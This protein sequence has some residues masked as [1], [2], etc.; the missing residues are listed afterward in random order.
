[1][2][3]KSVLQTRGVICIEG[4]D[5]Y[6]F[7][8]TLITNDVFLLETT[9]AI[10]TALLNHH[11]KYLF[12]VFIVQ[13]YQK[14]TDKLFLDVEKA[15]IPAVLKHL[16]L[17]KLRANVTITDRSD[18][19]RVASFLSNDYDSTLDSK[20]TVSNSFFYK[21][22]R[23]PVMGWRF[24]IAAQDQ[25][26]LQGCADEQTYQRHRLQQGIAESA[27]DLVCEKSIILEYGFD[28]LGAIAWNK[29]CYLG[30]ELMA[31][32]KHR[33]E[34]HKRLFK[35]KSQELPPKGTILTQNEQKIGTIV[36]QQGNW[37]IALLRCEQSETLEAL[38][39]KVDQ[40]THPVTVE[41]PLWWPKE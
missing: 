38:Q 16:H 1:M 23:T 36:Q 13:P 30:Q 4:I 24:L 29:G 25:D 19:Y 17:Y 7:L 28:S 9:P 22:P 12:D 14:N 39:A 6:Q 37:G 11:G 40:S 3:S 41:A 18:A 10:Y 26:L 20:L 27:E 15:K 2:T 8:Q 21:D 32:T 31:R 34:L 33:G 5:R 35:I